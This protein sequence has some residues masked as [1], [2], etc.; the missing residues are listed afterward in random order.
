MLQIKPLDNDKFFGLDIKQCDQRMIPKLIGC[1]P[2]TLAMRIPCW[3]SELQHVYITHINEEPVRNM[4]D[5]TRLFDSVC[6]K[7]L[8]EVKIGFAT[9]D[10]QVMH[11]Q[12]GVP[13]MYHDQM[14]I[15]GEHL[16]DIAHDP[17]LQ[18]CIKEEIALPVTPKSAFRIMKLTRAKLGK[19]GFWDLLNK[20]PTWYKI[21]TLK[22]AKKKQLTR[23]FLLQQDDW[24]DWEKSE[25]KQLNQYEAQKTFGNPCQLPKGANLL[26][27]LW[28]YLIK[29]SGTKKAPC[30]CNGSAKMKGTVTLGDTYAGSLEQTGSKNF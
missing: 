7:Q 12:L 16:W 5:V 13:Q 14:N 30:I 9:I 10:K 24:K 2:G 26:P 18:Q 22:K 11:P 29:D 6:T 1:K 21:A 15:I 17:A 27:L 28:T 8:K 20:L 19:N 4:D 23:H 3:R 25:H